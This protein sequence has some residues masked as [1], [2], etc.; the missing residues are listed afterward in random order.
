MKKT[1]AA[2][3]AHPLTYVVGFAV[4]GAASIVAGVAIVCGPG[5]A[6]IVAGGFMIGGSGFISRGMRLNG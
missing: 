5:L 3:A 6:L 2:I 1:L 4:A